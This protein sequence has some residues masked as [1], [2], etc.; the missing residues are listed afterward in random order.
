MRGEDGLVRV[1]AGQRRTLAAR[2][3]GLATVPVYVRPA[4]EGDEKAQVVERVSQQIVENDQRKALT[5]AQRVKGIQQMLDAGVSVTRVAKTLSVPRDTVKAAATAAG[6]TAAMDGLSSGQLSLAEA[7]AI[8]AFEDDPDA[9][10]ELL[11]VAGTGRFEHKLAE[12]RQQRESDKAYGEAVAS[13]TGQGYSVIEDYPGYYDT[14]HV[15]LRY[16][17]TA[18]GS[19]ATEEAITDPA[20]WAVHLTEDTAYVGRDTGESVDDDDI[21]WYC[22]HSAT[23]EPED[24]KRHPDTVTEHAV[25]TAEWFCT[26][27][28]AAGLQLCDTLAKRAQA[29][30]GGGPDGQDADAQAAAQAEAARLERRKTIA[31]NKLERPRRPY[32]ASSSATRSWRGKPHRRV[33]RCSWRTA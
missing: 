19:A 15:G 6:S 33:R 16:L 14:T 21:D 20:H 13:Y 4:S 29:G 3:A 24:G 17:R 5:D 2:Q 1:R 27:Y 8:T 12:I 10:A 30:G 26:D 11:R 7:A 9:L 18:D 23:G 25:F 22:R 31:L 32:V 28:A